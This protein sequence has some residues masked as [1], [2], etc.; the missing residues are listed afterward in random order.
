[1]RPF[2][3]LLMLGALLIMP[4]TRP[5]V[6][7][8]PPADPAAI[9]LWPA[10][11]WD[12]AARDNPAII[13][14]GVPGWGYRRVSKVQIPQLYAHQPASAAKPTPAVIICPGGGYQHLSFD[15]EGHD[16]ARWF[17]ERGITGIVLRYR[18]PAEPGDQSPFA[19][20][21]RAIRVVR[22]QATEL[23]VLSDKIGVMGFSAG[24]HLASVAATHFDAGDSASS[25]PVE[26][27]SSRP[28][29][30]VLIY[31]V[32]SLHAATSHG[33][34]RTQV[35]GENP[36]PAEETKYS[37]EE[38]VT[39]D[40]PPAFLLHTADDQ[41]VPFENSLNYAVALRNHKVPVELHVYAA[42]G[43]GYGM[44]AGKAPV[45]GW[46]TLLETWLRGRQLIE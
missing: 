45:H 44:L 32:I 12:A 25:D 11:K 22:A 31:P 46:P 13:E 27:V 37:G 29:F 8:E 18:L 2:I 5:V 20:V 26:R 35:L 39:K 9:D 1:M 6:A 15:K 14:T 34:S 17:A 7:Q 19:D 21:Q 43:H 28:D 23:N 30:Q 10:D 24:G 38:Q 36:S 4:L 41:A 42:G 3:P 16:V 40:S 33:G